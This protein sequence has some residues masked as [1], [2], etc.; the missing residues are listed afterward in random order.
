MSN[1]EHRLAPWV[2]APVSILAWTMAI[3]FTVTCQFF[4]LVLLTPF[5]L[6]FDRSRKRVEH[7]VARAWARF[8]IGSSLVWRLQVKGGEN[9]KAG[10]H[11]VVIA[12][13][14]SLLDIL[15]VLAGLDLQF[16]FL[17]K[18]ELFSI[19]F[20]GWHM[21]NA[22]YIPL[23]RGNRDSA[24]TAMGMAHQ[25]IQRGVS[26]LFFPEGTRSLDGEIHVFK[27]GAFRLAQSEGVE[28]LPVV[29]DGTGDALPKHSWY[30][31]KKTR[32]RLYIGK[33]VPIGSG[34]A[35][36]PVKV[37]ESVRKKMIE[38]LAAMREEDEGG[39]S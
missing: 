10:K 20:L 23:E 26:V 17:A 2:S 33:P 37:M 22:G 27:P 21:K 30:L 24:R 39:K 3:F 11:Y 16:K 14:Q 32:F 13:H 25:H 36:A 28:I 29:I 5:S 1:S 9:I 4:G 35:N 12:N 18:K 34:D 31:E 6:I 8:I 19:P 38:T 7:R 15:V